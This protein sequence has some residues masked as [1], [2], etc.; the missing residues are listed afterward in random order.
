MKSVA[1]RVA[2]ASVLSIIKAWLS[3]AVVERTGGRDR[4]ST[5]ARDRRR[6]TPQGGVI[7]P[8]LANLYFRRFV[9]AWK[10][11]RESRETDGAIVNYADDFV[12][13]CAP[14]T[15][16]IA[17]AKTRDLMRRLGLS[18][19]DEKTRVVDATCTRFDFLGYSV[20]TFHGRNGTPFLGTAPSEKSIKAVKR[21]IHEETSCRWNSTTVESRVREINR[22]L[23][24]WC[25]YFDQGPVQKTYTIVTEY[26][27]RRL[28]RWLMRKHKKRGTGYRQYPDE[29]LFGRL[30]LYKPTA[31]PRSQPSAKA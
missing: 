2:D 27:G 15:A 24:G 10:K 5:E 13:C 17:I 16:G 9:L 29:V 12:I 28:R 11:S 6:G 3:V 22:I 25:G 1:R 7:S 23:R 19:N 14:G 4:Y 21:K 30:G 26:T 20:G 8:L 31:R 18:V